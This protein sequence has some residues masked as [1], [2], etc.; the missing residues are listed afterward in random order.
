MIP[1]NQMFSSSDVSSSGSNRVFLIRMPSVKLLPGVGK[2]K[3]GSSFL[4]SM[5]KTWRERLVRRPTLSN[6]QNTTLYSVGDHS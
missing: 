4:T 2:V 6:I 3:M 5:S 1:D